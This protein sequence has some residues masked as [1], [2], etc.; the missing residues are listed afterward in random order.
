MSR[1]YQGPNR[2]PL[3]QRLGPRRP[4]PPRERPWE[5]GGPYHGLS[6]RQRAR[7]RRQEQER[8]AGR[9]DRGRP[10]RSPLTRHGRRGRP[11][12][13]RQN[14]VEAEAEAEIEAGAEAPAQGRNPPPSPREIEVDEEMMDHLSLDSRGQSPRPPSEPEDHIEESRDSPV[15]GRL[16]ED[17]LLQILLGDDDRME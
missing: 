14:G 8:S 4:C 5:H 6:R 11:P 2:G 10:T 1:R 9:S 12:L 16:Q 17:D 7:L 3:S 13:Q 15:E